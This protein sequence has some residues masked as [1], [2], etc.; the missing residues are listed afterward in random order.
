MQVHWRLQTYVKQ[1][2][3]KNLICIGF[4]ANLRVGTDR[5]L[6]R[7]VGT[8]SSLRDCGQVSQAFDALN[9]QGLNFRGSNSVAWRSGRGLSVA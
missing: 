8:I 6:Q 2:F 3:R 1:S 9:V 5:G 4:V 7:L